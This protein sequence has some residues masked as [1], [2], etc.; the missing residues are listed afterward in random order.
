M[1]ASDLDWKDIVDGERV[2]D[3]EIVIV[4]PS[5]VPD[6]LRGAESVLLVL[7]TAHDLTTAWFDELG[8]GRIALA[9]RAKRSRT[10]AVSP[11]YFVDRAE[12]DAL[13]DLETRGARF[14]VQ[15]IP[16]DAAEA[17]DLEGIAAQ[18][19]TTATDRKPRAQQ[20]GSC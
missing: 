17:I 11:T 5:E 3:S 20:R 18:I 15:R 16:A 12:V 6:R 14:T 4:T 8:E 19:A 2:E 1:V 9:N 13:R 10:V 7:G